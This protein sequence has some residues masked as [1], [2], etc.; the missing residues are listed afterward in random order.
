MPADRYRVG[1]QEQEFAPAG[2]EFGVTDDVDAPE[3]GRGMGEALGCT[4]D[5][6]ARPQHRVG[7]TADDGIFERGD[8]GEAWVL[9][10]TRGEIHTSAPRLVQR[11]SRGTDKAGQVLDTV[12]LAQIAVGQR[13]LDRIAQR[14][15][16]DAGDE[17][18]RQS[19]RKLL[20]CHD[21][22]AVPL[23]PR[24]IQPDFTSSQPAMGDERSA[25]H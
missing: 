10:R 22:D 7:E 4:R 8:G 19:S 14:L 21:L 24:S 20:Q 23:G 11:V 15:R 12:E 17:P 13:C 6:I 5:E 25:L 2:R 1:Q 16:I 3:Q 9:A 18:T